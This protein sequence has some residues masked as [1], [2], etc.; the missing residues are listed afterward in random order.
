MKNKRM[1]IIPTA[2][3][4]IFAIFVGCG[5]RTG[6]KE[7][8]KA[9]DAWKSGNLAQARTLFDQSIRKTTGN[10]KKS[11]AWNQLGLV[12]W[13]LGE[14]EAAAKAFNESCTLS[15]N[16]TGA[17][18]NLGIALFHLGRLNE[19][20]IALNNVLGDNPK[21][22]SAQTMLGLIAAQ[23]QD[24]TK[25]SSGIALVASADSSDPAS[26]NALTLM[27]LQKTKNT[28]NTIQSLKQLLVAH[29]GYAPA[30]YNLGVIYDQW[31]GNKA[32]AVEW[33][34]SYLRLAGSDESHV[35]AAKQSIA[36]LSGQATTPTTSTYDTVAA[37]RFMKEGADLYAAKKYAEAVTQYQKA[38]QSDSRMKSAHYNMALAYFALSKSADA[39]KA[40]MNALQIDPRYADARYMLTYIYFQQRK[41]D[42]AERE[43]KTL[44]QVD[45]TRGAQMLTY[46][47]DARKR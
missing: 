45:P 32:S 46:I 4:V 39:E 22:T 5:G 38:I 12:L 10:E 41:W 25:A 9:M 29:P 28:D 13:E 31:L 37:T 35:D 24:W 40:C 42:D 3:V 14:T 16:V 11:L 23:K 7:Y 17:N 36:R 30:A 1:M 21:N 26:Q 44:E 2:A 33:Y 20:E 34:R 6:E 47:S 18:L 43:A 19:A 15:E 27:E 8:K